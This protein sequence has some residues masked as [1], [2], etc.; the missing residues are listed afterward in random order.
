M[1]GHFKW[2]LRKQ[3]AKRRSDAEARQEEFPLKLIKEITVTCA[4]RAAAASKQT[5]V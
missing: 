2:H 5:R 1:S 3:R 4:G